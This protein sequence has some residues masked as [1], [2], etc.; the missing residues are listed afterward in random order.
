M[1]ESKII[2]EYILKNTSEK[3]EETPFGQ[4]VV[5][6]V[7]KAVAEIPEIK[8]ALEYLAEQEDAELE[9]NTKELG[10]SYATATLNKVREDMIEKL[11]QMVEDILAS[12]M[13]EMETSE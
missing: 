11:P 12:I 6:E 8:I 9:A 4:I 7:N 13:S 3:F 2:Q 10:K 5:D 1:K